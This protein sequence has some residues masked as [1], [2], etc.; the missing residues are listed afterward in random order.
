[1]PFGMGPAGWF[2]WPYLAQWMRYCYPGYGPFHWA[3]YPPMSEE[4]EKAM[5]EQQKKILEKQL[6]QI[7]K[8]LTE[9]KKT[10]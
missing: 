4:E 7:N 8:R 5:L 3:P 6:A 10:K 2:M 1:M 9:L